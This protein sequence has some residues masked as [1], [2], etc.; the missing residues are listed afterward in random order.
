M[1]ILS[2]S[3]LHDFKVIQSIIILIGIAGIV[4]N[5][6]W[7]SAQISDFYDLNQKAYLRRYKIG[8]SITKLL[9]FV[10]L[11]LVDFMAKSNLGLTK[12][13]TV[14]GVI[15]LIIN[16]VSISI[17]MIKR[18]VWIYC[19]ETDSLMLEKEIELLQLKRKVSLESVRTDEAELKSY[20]ELEGSNLYAKDKLNAQRLTA[21]I[22]LSQNKNQYQE[23]EESRRLKDSNLIDSSLNNIKDEQQKINKR[24]LHE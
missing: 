16:L 24:N 6:S 17:L 22:S 20:Q 1:V 5:N 15:L 13:F 23:D 2:L 18:I 10:A 19:S 8:D 3:F 7:D 11:F 12:T 14:V 21:N 4:F 9:M